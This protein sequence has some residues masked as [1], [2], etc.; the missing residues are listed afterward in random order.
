MEGVFAIKEPSGLKHK[1]VLLIDDVVT[2]GASLE[3]CGLEIL[4]VDG[5]RLSVVTLAYTL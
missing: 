1:H 3:A 5:A 4:K 2:T